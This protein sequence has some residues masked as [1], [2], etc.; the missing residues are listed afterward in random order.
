MAIKR[1]GQAVEKQ[2]LAAGELDELKSHLWYTSNAPMFGHLS[3][4]Q[5]S[6]MGIQSQVYK[7]A[8]GVAEEIN[9]RALRR[10]VPLSPSKQIHVGG[11]ERTM[12]GSSDKTMAANKNLVPG[13][14]KT[15][16]RQEALDATM[17]AGARNKVKN[18]AK[19]QSLHRMAARNS[20]KNNIIPGKRHRSM[21]QE[22][23]DDTFQ[24]VDSFDKTLIP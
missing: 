9:M 24:P 10:D 5:A 1:L 8:Q 17:A 12:A 13:L 19:A 20:A 21:Q 3:K 23:F 15:Q 14:D 16:A 18:R 2:T 6:A 4:K 7:S 22:M 11:M